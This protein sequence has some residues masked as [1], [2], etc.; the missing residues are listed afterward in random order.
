[1]KSR[2]FEEVRICVRQKAGSCVDIH[3][4]HTEHLA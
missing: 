1:V 3:G 4:S 2:I